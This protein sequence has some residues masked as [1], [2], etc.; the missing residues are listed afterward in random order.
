MEEQPQ[1]FAATEQLAVCDDKPRQLKTGLRPTCREA[2][3]WALEAPLHSLD[4]GRRGRPRGV[5]QPSPVKGLAEKA[6]RCKGKASAISAVELTSKEHHKGTPRGV[7]AEISE[8]AGST[9]R[10][11]VSRLTEKGTRNRQERAVAGRALTRRASD[12]KGGRWRRGRSEPTGP[13]P[14]LGPG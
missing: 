10:K 8:T 4:S 12:H 2:G 9:R 13:T 11:A 7:W 5:A 6:P 1:L 14:R 3:M